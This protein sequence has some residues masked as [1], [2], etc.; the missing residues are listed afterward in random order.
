MK[1]FLKF[2]SAFSSVALITPLA[3]A[4]ICPAPWQSAVG[5]SNDC[6]RQELT[7]ETWSEFTG[8][9]SEVKANIRSGY[10]AENPNVPF[11][12]NVI[13]YEGLGD[14]MVNHLPLFTKLTDAGYR[15][16]AFDY[17]G[18][19]GSSG[20]MD[21][22]R[23]LEIGVLG[24]KIWNLHARDLANFPK[25][26]IIGWSTGGLAAYMQA[27]MKT[28]VSNIVLIAPGIVPNKF[29]GEQRP[30]ELRFN[31]ITLPTLTTQVYTSG[32][33]N[34]HIDPIKPTSPFEVKAFA[35]DLMTEAE[36]C[37]GNLMSNR[38]NGFV[39]LS[40]DND[41]YVDAQ[42]TFAVLKQDAPHFS[43]LQYPGSLHEI[44]NEVEPT[45]S[46]VQRDI[47]NF[48]NKNN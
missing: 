36:A 19:G 2:L 10:L 6:I 5:N 35:Y 20:S 31:V 40:G 27:Q 7:L 1:Q 43:V 34:P 26:N 39:L 4:R 3:F 13:Y 45:R 38:V 46:N 18:Q 44:D 42:E 11:R 25:K 8:A 37:R 33:Q 48:L 47:L 22:T 29:V 24:D 30:L 32:V 41:T 15:V 21:D 16:I 28:D 9:R 12:G 17:M 14:S 23:I